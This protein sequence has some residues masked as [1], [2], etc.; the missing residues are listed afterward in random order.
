MQ[1]RQGSQHEHADIT[2]S[3]DY[4]GSPLRKIGKTIK[5]I[6]FSPLITFLSWSSCPER[7]SCLARSLA[8]TA[9]AR[10]PSTA[11]YTAG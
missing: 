4:P 1:V 3:L 8:S 10:C 9:A 11:R 5:Q 2:E 7:V 6:G